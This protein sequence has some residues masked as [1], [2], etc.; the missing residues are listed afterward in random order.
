LRAAIALLALIALVALFFTKAMPTRPP[1]RSGTQTSDQS[2]S[3][4]G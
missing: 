2:S 4:T 3:D 1:G